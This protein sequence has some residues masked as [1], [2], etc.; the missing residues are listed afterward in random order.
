[1]LESIKKIFTESAHP[2]KSQ[3][4]LKN[5][6]GHVNR[7]MSMMK[8]TNDDLGKEKTIPKILQYINIKKSASTRNQIVCAIKKYC[9][10][11]GHKKLDNFFAKEVEKSIAIRKGEIEK[12]KIIEKKKKN[13]VNFKILK[14]RY[15][16]SLQIVKFYHKLD[17]NLT[18]ENTCSD[19]KDNLELAVMLGLYVSDIKLNPP[20]RAEAFYNCEVV[21]KTPKQKNDIKNYIVTSRN[22]PKKIILY[23]YK[24]FDKYGRQE[25]ELNPDLSFLLKKWIEFYK[26]IPGKNLFK[27]LNGDKWGNTQFSIKIKKII[28]KCCL[29]KKNI[30]T[31]MLRNICITEMYKDVDVTDI[32]KLAKMSGHC[33]DTA[34]EHYIQSNNLPTDTKINLDDITIL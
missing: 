15:E 1:M 5:Y 16:L 29:E 11:L 34:C 9:L 31:N 30:S 4:S 10:A 14:K 12:K 32:P 19:Y 7:L 2:I 6:S 8:L 28:Q 18:I 17:T 26:N 13:W 21:K 20:R 22:I 24:T 33:F 27:K 23:R 3:A 25:Y